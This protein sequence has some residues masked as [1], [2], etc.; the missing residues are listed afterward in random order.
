MNGKIQITLPQGIE[1][2]ERLMA[3]SQ[4]RDFI[5]CFYPELVK[6][7]GKTYDI[8][9]VI[10]TI[11]MAISIATKSVPALARALPPRIGDYL[12]ALIKDEEAADIANA[13]WCETARPLRTS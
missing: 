9:G 8:P 4:E 5:R 10:M 12:Y 3:V 1:L 2:M 7:A 6:C 11:H 13:F